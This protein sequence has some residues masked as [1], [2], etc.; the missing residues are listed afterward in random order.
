MGEVDGELVVIMSQ[1][2]LD[3]WSPKSAIRVAI[4]DDRIIAIVDYLFCPGLIGDAQSVIVLD[5]PGIMP[6][7]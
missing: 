2:T 1:R 6:G 4:R 3:G 7:G 5:P